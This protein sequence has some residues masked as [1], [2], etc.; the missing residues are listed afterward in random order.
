MRGRTNR[1]L[2]VSDVCGENEQQPL[3]QAQTQERGHSRC[4]RTGEVKHLHLEIERE[5]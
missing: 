4:H 2:F 1:L 5:S 3:L